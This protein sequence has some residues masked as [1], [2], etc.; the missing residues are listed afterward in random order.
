M[1]RKFFTAFFAVCVPGFSRS[2]LE[3]A[4]ST[5][6]TSG[7]GHLLKAFASDLTF[8]RESS[9]ICASLLLL[10]VFEMLEQLLRHLAVLTLRFRLIGALFFVGSGLVLGL[11]GGFVVHRPSKR[12]LN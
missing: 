6:L 11:F 2:S 1:I 8:L 9:A 12:A 3:S 10:P 4:P 5:A 7:F